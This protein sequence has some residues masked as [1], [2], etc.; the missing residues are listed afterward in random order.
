M[1]KLNRDFADTIRELRTERL[2]SQEDLSQ[3]ASIN[4]TYLSRME[5]GLHLPSLAALVRL[6]EAFGIT[7]ADLVGRAESRFRKPRRRR[8][9]STATL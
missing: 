7:A 3:R 4:R 9:I 2:I 6:A 8:A 1:N 5:R